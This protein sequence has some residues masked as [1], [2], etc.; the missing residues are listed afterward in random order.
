MKP[1]PSRMESFWMGVIAGIIFTLAFIPVPAQAE[2]HWGGL[3]LASRHFTADNERYCEENWG[4]FYEYR[5]GPWGVQVGY[6]RNSW[7][8]LQTEDRI[9]DTFYAAAV[10]QPWRFL[11]ADAGWFAG[12]ASGYKKGNLV[13]IAGAMLTWKAT[14]ETAVQVIVNPAV[15]GLQLKL[16][17]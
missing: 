10:Y 4:G 7:C 15:A 8:K 9:D 5:E 13:L 3:N 6:Y 14:P 12:P 11:G 16:R 1:L 2:E 17:F